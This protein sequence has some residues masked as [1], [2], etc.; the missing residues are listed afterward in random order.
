MAR[1][2]RILGVFFRCFSPFPG[3]HYH[4][5]VIIR[6]LLAVNV[7]ELILLL[8]GVDDDQVHVAHAAERRVPRGVHEAEGEIEEYESGLKRYLR[9]T[10][11]PIISALQYALSLQYEVSTMRVV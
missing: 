4:D 9:R 7:C 6:A 10:A 8:R 5:D 11:Y 3:F 2:S 1:A